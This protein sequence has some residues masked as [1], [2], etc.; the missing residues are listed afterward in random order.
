MTRWWEDTTLLE[1]LDLEGVDEDDIYAA[2][3]RLLARQKR[4][5][6]KPAGRHPKNDDMVLYDPEVEL[7]RGGDMSPGPDGQEPA[8]VYDLLAELTM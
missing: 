7:L 5:E 2:V 3:D 1:L 4:I 8:Q 6:K